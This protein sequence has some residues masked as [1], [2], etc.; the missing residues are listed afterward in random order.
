MNK[1]VE[2]RRTNADNIEVR[3]EGEQDFR[4]V[5]DEIISAYIIYTLTRDNEEVFKNVNSRLE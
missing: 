4:P 1:I 2:V 3:F 5:T